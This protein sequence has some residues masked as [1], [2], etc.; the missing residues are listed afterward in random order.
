MELVAVLVGVFI[1][2]AIAFAVGYRNKAREENRKARE[3][4]AR[5]KRELAYWTA[6]NAALKALREEF[7]RQRGGA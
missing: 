4:V 7:K 1:T 5:L 2:F 3:E 6:K